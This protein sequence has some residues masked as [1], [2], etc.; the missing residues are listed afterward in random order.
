MICMI[1]FLTFIS[2]SGSNKGIPSLAN[3]EI[4]S[5]TFLNVFSRAS[6]GKRSFGMCIRMLLSPSICELD[7]KRNTLHCYKCLEH[8]KFTGQ[9][10]KGNNLRKWQ[11]NDNRFS[12]VFQRNNLHCLLSTFVLTYR[13]SCENINCVIRI[14]RP[15]I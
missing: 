11:G 14:L 5:S 10:G 3:L 13:T 9:I 15:P 12:T 2:S 7:R 4:T 8:K 6:T 1:F